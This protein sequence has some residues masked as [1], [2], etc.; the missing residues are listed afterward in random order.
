MKKSSF[1]AHIASLIFSL[2]CDCAWAM[3]AAQQQAGWAKSAQSQ[4]AAF[5]P[6]AMRGKALY[7]YAFN[8]HADMASCVACHTADPRAQGKHAITSKS[9]APLSPLANPERFADAVKTE[10]WFK[11]NCTDVAGRECSAAEKADFVEFLTKGLK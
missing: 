6:S 10:K 4:D 1:F 7:E 3:D 2:C 5:K 8:K 9:I 11:R